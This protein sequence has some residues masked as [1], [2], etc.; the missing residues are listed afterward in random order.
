M[1][2][3]HLQRLG[4]QTRRQ[5]PWG[6]P[7]AEGLPSV[8]IAPCDPKWKVQ[9]AERRRLA[10][11]LV[12]ADGGRVQGNEYRTEADVEVADGEAPLRRVAVDVAERGHRRGRPCPIGLEG[13]LSPRSRTLG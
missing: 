4:H 13:G 1:T 9:V 11:C 2:S 8:M 7:V 10:S 3:A 6:R 5:G 12:L